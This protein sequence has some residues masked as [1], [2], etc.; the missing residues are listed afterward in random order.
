MNRF[1]IEFQN[2]E[3]LADAGTKAS[4]DIS[5]ILSENGYRKLFFKTCGGS[6]FKQISQ[7]L[8]SSIKLVVS[9]KRG[10][11]VIYQYPIYSRKGILAFRFV[12]K[13]LKLKKVKV[14]AFIHDI[15]SARSDV[16]QREVEIEELNK[17]DLIVVHS[18]QMESW[19]REAGCVKPCVRLGLFDYLVSKSNEIERSLSYT[20]TY[21]G[22]LSSSK[23]GFVYHLKDLTCKGH[24]RFLLYGRKDQN[25]SFGDGIEYCGLFSPD[26]VSSLQG[27]WGLVW[28]GSSI[29]DL[30][31][32]TG[33]YQRINSP[34]K[35][36]LYVVAGLPLIVNSKAAIADVVVEHNLGITIDSLAELE[37]RISAISSEDYAEMLSCVNAYAERLMT[38]QNLL[39]V[40]NHIV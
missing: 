6:I 27:S 12:R 21:A 20:V 31:G 34:H 24:L 10:S 8:S 35:A 32:Q 23:S 14:V 19:L 11:L 40:L 28:D 25:D 16:R 22:I 9:A 26:D 3:K 2:G 7:I 4:A 38:G 15:I 29:D 5:T 1:I 39:T 17:N 30:D 13:F 36:S 37:E 18:S 33:I